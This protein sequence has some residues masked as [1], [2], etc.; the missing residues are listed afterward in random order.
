M[1]SGPAVSGWPGAPG[2]GQPSQGYPA[3]QGPLVGGGAG[4]DD[5][6]RRS[7]PVGPRQNVPTSPVGNL[8]H[9]CQTCGQLTAPDAVFCQSCHQTIA[10]ECP[11]CRLALL[12][13]QD[14]CPRCHTPNDAF[15]G[16]AHQGR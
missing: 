11:V 13:I 9:V 1:P 5:P 7:A 10:R 15:V 12:P 6:F 3:P 14:R 16:R 4:S 8:L 2:R